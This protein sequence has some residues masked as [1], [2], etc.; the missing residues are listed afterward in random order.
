MN[1][2]NAAVPDAVVRFAPKQNGKS[3]TSDTLENAGHLILEMVN[4]AA[5][6]AEAGYQQ[7]V[8]SNRKL[9]GQLRGAED[10]I[11]EL[12]VEVRRYQDR[13]DRAEKWLYQIS[14]EIEQMLLGMDDRRHS[15][16]PAP[17]AVAGQK[18]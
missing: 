7:A 15:Q 10:R 8:E 16:P 9:S 18:R 4:K 5:N 6:A 13:A 3:E 14:V 11:R 2:R 17:Q 1:S 12:E